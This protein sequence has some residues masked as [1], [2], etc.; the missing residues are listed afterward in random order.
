MR[1]LSTTGNRTQ[2]VAWPYEAALIKTAVAIET[3]MLDCLVSAIND[4]TSTSGEANGVAF[5]RHRNDELCE[6]LV[7]GGGYFDFKGGQSG[8]VRVIK[9]LVGTED[10]LYRVVKGPQ[11]RRRVLGEA[12]EEV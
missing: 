3:L 5:P 1:P 12:S 8:L 4:D 2:A 7:T 11:R 6:Y 9:K 10:Y